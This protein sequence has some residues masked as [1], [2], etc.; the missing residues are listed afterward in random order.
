[1]QDKDHEL[2]YAKQ[3]QNGHRGW[4]R[5]QLAPAE[6]G[7]PESVPVQGTC[8]RRGTGA[9]TAGSITVQPTQVKATYAD[10]MATIKKSVQLVLGPPTCDF[11]LF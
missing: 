1:M 9:T 7:P 2:K 10:P 8:G 11:D 4:T 5:Q 6:R 3:T